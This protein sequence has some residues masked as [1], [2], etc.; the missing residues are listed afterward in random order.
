MEELTMWNS[1][2]Q[3]F[4]KY[5][6]LLKDK[7]D[8]VQGQITKEQKNKF[9]KIEQEYLKKKETQIEK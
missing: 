3:L 5:S 1:E 4:T 9:K 8:L 2:K 7:K 6:T